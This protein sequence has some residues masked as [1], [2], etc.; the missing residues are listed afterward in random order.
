MK[1]NT[2]L[3]PKHGNQDEEKVILSP[4]ETMKN[5]IAER[6][7]LD[8]LMDEKLKEIMKLLEVE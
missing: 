5:F 3:L 1:K 8:R 6:E 4:E 7:H 2:I